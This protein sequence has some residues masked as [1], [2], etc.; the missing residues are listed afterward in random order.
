M[1]VITKLIIYTF[2]SY[3]ECWW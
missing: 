2:P 3:Y 1:H